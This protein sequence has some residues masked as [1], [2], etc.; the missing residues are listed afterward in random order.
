[1]EIKYFFA[2]DITVGVN[3]IDERPHFVGSVDGHKLDVIPD[4]GAEINIID[5]Q[6]YNEMHPKLRHDNT[7]IL[8]YVSPTSLPVKGI[9]PYVSPTSLPV[10]GILPYVSPTSLPVK[11]ILPYVSPTSLPVKGIFIANVKSATQQSDDIFYV[12][13]GSGGSLLGWKAS[14]RLNLVCAV[15]Q[16]STTNQCNTAVDQLVSEYDYLFQGLG[17]LGRV[18]VKLH[19]D[20]N[21]KHIAQPHRRIPFHVRKQLDQELKRDE[22][23]G[24][25]ERVEG[26]TYHHG[27]HRW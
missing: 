20:D 25:I 27:Y 9:L 17:Q 12:V 8:P 3:K 13:A 21:V 16:V 19:I 15:E 26:Y 14:K 4:S 23:L 2:C 10:K 18:K 24:V 6:H 22:E 11:G 1:M 7:K 5:E